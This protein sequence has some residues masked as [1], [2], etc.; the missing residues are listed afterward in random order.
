M[1]PALSP[2]VDYELRTACSLVLQSFKSP[3][4][5]HEEPT[6]DRNLSTLQLDN[7]TI[8]ELADDEEV[9]P[10]PPAKVGTQTQLAQSEVEQAAN[11]QIIDKFKYQPT[12][13]TGG[14]FGNVDFDRMK[15][16][17]SS[18]I[19]PVENIVSSELGGVKSLNGYKSHKRSGSYPLHTSLPALRTD[20]LERPRTAPR[21]DSIHTRGSTPL[22]DVTEYPWT[23]STAPTSAAITPARNSQRASSHARQSWSGSSSAPK[24]VTGD[25]ESMREELEKHKRAQEEA[26][27]QQELENQVI[28]SLAA[29]ARSMPAPT[30]APT[31][32]VQTP[33]ATTTNVQAHAVTPAQVPRRKPVP[34]SSTDSRQSAT[35]QQ[36]E[37]RRS[38]DLV[39]RESSRRHA[40]PRSESRHELEMLSRPTS[41]ARTSTDE[42]RNDSRSRFSQ[43]PFRS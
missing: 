11:E 32:A 3:R 27:A 42:D 31:H 6:G 14:A 2:G 39:R 20:L 8:E 30:P 38:N 10:P 26:K 12:I 1:R 15:A 25:A 24:F 35:A 41:R 9:R 22:T 13:A 33:T 40:A 5:V 34:R 4:E 18:V 19:Q 21:S 23:S 29:D 7:A 43:K 28:E 37:S 17:R 36:V 16:Q